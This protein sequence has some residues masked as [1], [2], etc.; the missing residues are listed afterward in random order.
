M[1]KLGFIPN[2]DNGR[3]HD[4]VRFYFIPNLVCKNFIA[5]TSCIT[6]VCD[7]NITV[8]YATRVALH[9]RKR[10]YEKNKVLTISE[11]RLYYR[12]KKETDRKQIWRKIMTRSEICF[13]TW[14]KI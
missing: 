1:I 2:E 3:T 12:Y 4:D 9:V 8:Y 7:Y 11:H 14:R 5:Y 10:A 13:L 6:M